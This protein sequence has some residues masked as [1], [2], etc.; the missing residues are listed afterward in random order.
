MH[1]QYFIF[2]YARFDDAMTLYKGFSD[3][4]C[5]VFLLNCESPL[6]PSFEET[7][8][9][10]KLP[11][12]YYSGQWNEALKLLTGNVAFLIN[13]DVKIKSIPRLIQKM[14]SFYSKYGD[15]A[16][17]YAPNLHWT[18]WTYNPAR[19]EDLGNG[20][21]RVPATDST[22]WSVCSSLAHKV[23][24]V[25]LSINKL[26]WGI[27]V[28]AAYY[29]FLEKKLVVRDYSIKLEH[30]NHTAYNRT[31]ADQT[32]RK[33]ANSL[34]LGREFWRYYDSRDKYGFGWVGNDTPAP[35]IHKL[36]L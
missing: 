26:G 5:D 31:E 27:E 20:V 32:W 1:I 25:D 13:S 22:V 33:W 30:P 11:N 35:T 9:I 3:A 21:K 18:P 16:G 17:I 6:D 14:Q 10:K 8:R 15:K 7:D 4:S 28:V 36:M 19:L 29:A 12:I 24:P 23:G 34:G 2:N